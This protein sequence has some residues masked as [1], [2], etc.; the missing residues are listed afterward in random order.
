MLMRRFLTG[1]LGAALLPLPLMAKDEPTKVAPGTPVTITVQPAAPA[2]PPVSIQLDDRHGHITPTRTGF[3]HTGGGYIDVQQPTPDVLV[4]T[5]MGVAVAGPHPCK[6]SFAQ[7]CFD[8]NQTLEISFD[9]PKVKAAKLTME[10]RVI[11]LLR[12]GG[13]GTAEETDGCAVLSGEGCDTLTVCA[14]SHSVA[15]CENLSLN[16][17]SGPVSGPIKAGK[18]CLHGT[19]T[20]DAS[21]PRSL[22]CDKAAS[23]EFDPAALD[24]LWISYW[25]PYHGVKK[26]DF[27]LQ[28]TIKVADDTA[29]VPAE[30]VPPPKPE[31]GK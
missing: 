20:I 4:V 7:L 22:G 18:Y 15:A 21:H 26:A 19:W 8:L 6:A 30:P 27:G 10:A 12:G 28:F 11:G 9:D 29:N 16:D 2:A 5:M 24:P 14:P 17:H 25:E 31:P 23:A 1:L 3:T 13:K